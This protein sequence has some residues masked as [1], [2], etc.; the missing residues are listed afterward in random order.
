MAEGVWSVAKIQHTEVPDVVGIWIVYPDDGLKRS[1]PT[2]LRKLTRKLCFPMGE[3]PSRLGTL[4]V[5][6]VVVWS[7]GSPGQPLYVIL[8]LSKSSS[9][10]TTRNY[11]RSR[12]SPWVMLL[13]VTGWW[14]RTSSD[15]SADFWGN[16]PMWG[17]HT[18]YKRLQQK[19]TF[20]IR[21]SSSSHPNITS[22]E[23]LSPK[24]S[25]YRVK[26]SEKG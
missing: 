20:K 10:W 16:S 2:P 13:D 3:K 14:K 1:E 26:D 4:N 21:K 25:P 18:S 6:I 12:N 15:L 11:R 7:Q 5:S 24:S 19:P 22:I 17:S 9:V 8:F 23:L